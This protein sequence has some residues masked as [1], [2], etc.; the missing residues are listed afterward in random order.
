MHV[1]AR[2]MEQCGPGDVLVTMAVPPL[3]TGSG[4]AVVDR[5]V[6][7]LRGVPGEWALMA[8]RG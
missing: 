3:V 2:V 4:F 7:P 6:Y 1:A 8:R 5:G